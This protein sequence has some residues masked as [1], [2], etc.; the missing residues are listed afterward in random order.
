MDQSARTYCSW[1]F[2][3]G[4]FIMVLSVVMHIYLLKYLDLTLLSANS[5]VSVAFAI[6]LSTK[7]LGEVFIWQYDLVALIFI[8]AGCT[9]I[10]LNA[11]TI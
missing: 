7:I 8:V 4:L 1:R 10:V 6:I 5:A 9:T 3:L 11:N 2:L